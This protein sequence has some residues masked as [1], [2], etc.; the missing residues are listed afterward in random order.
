MRYA[1]LGF[2]LAASVAVLTLV[3]WWV[4][5][6]FGSAPW[7]VLA[8]AL[9]GLVG[10]MYNMVR[11]ALESVR[12]PHDADRDEAKGPADDGPGRPRP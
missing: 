10:G 5:R 11:Q 6:H 3:G 7:G 2:E 8:G 9:I 4:D 12:P 1:G